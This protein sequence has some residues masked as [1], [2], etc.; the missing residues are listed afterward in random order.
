LIDAL[1]SSA[2]VRHVMA[3]LVSGEQ[4]YRTLVRRLIATL[5]VR[6]AWNLLRLKFGR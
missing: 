4:S 6:L 2:A 5:E 1:S 3:D